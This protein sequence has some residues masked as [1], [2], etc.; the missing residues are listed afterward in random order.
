MHALQDGCLS[1]ILCSLRAELCALLGSCSHFMHS[2]RCLTR[3]AA[4]SD[5]R[6]RSSGCRLVNFAEHLPMLLLFRRFAPT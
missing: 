5:G 2:S 4:S 1:N 6:T 3:H